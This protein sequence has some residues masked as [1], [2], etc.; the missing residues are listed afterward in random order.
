MELKDLKVGD[1]VMQEQRSY[2]K[3]ERKVVGYVFRTITKVTPTRIHALGSVFD[4]STGR[5]KEK[6]NGGFGTNQTNILIVTEEALAWKEADT[7][8]RNEARRKNNEY[9]SREDVKIVRDLTNTTDTAWLALG[10]DRLKEIAAIISR[11]A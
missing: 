9:E 11:P 10:L 1:V 2:V 3:G 8:S 5:C 7:K 4:R 6:F